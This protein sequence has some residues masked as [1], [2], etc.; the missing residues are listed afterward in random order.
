[1]ALRTLFQVDLARS[2]PKRAF[3]YSLES[4]ELNESDTE[5]AWRLVEGTL[6]HLDEIDEVI[7]RAAIHW[8]VER[9]ARTDRNVLRMAVYELRYEK[10]VPES[11]TVNEAVELAKTYGDA[12]SGKFVN[13]VLGHVLR[14]ASRS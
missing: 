5:F 9:M 8:T 3:A 1:M 7:R 14:E 6:A 10:D 2:N 11:V 4:F 13:G 12:D